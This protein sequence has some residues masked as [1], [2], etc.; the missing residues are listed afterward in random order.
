MNQERVRDLKAATS[1]AI[2][3]STS[4]SDLEWTRVSTKLKNKGTEGGAADSF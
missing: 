1:G 4:E 2:S 3:L